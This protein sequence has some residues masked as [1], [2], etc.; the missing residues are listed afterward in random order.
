[1][2]DGYSL[3]WRV[4]DAQFWVPQRRKRIYL[5][6]D[7]GSEHAGEILFESESVSGDSEKSREERQGTAAD[8][9]GS[10]G[11]SRVRCLNQGD[12]QSKHVLDINGISETLC[13][14]E[15]R[16]AGL[17]PIVFIQQR[18]D[19]YKSDE[20]A[21]TLKARD[22]KDATDLIVEPIDKVLCVGNGQSDIVGH[23]SNVA[24]TLNCMHDQQAIIYPGRNKKYII[25]RLTPLE[26]CRLQGFPDW[27]EDG[28]N[29]SDTARYRMW[30][31][32]V[33]LPCAIDA[34][35]RICKLAEYQPN[36]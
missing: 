14:A 11:R 4:Y 13:A 26:C 31:N 7:F 21:S 6:A 1:M 16:W 23:I 17:S 35:S 3:A 27:W 28:A 19:E 30:G 36:K 29:G 9:E 20:V 5:I 15:K 22:Y 8:A 34:V 32:G 18:F 10:S 33:A 24:G 2:G 25:R 12:P